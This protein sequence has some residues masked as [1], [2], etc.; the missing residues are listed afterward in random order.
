MINPK[1]MV[2]IEQFFPNIIQHHIR[3][4]SSLQSARDGLVRYRDLGYRT[5]ERLSPDQQDENRKAL[6][7][8]YTYS[9]KQLE[10]FHA[11]EQA[12]VTEEVQS[13][14]DTP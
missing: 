9:V 11:R 8:A 14:T 5:I 10:G 12:P 1:V 2:I 7:E 13:D 6:D 3:T 4:R